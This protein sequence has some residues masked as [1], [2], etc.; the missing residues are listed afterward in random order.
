VYVTVSFTL[1]KFCDDTIY[2]FDIDCDVQLI[3][4]CSNQE[5]LKIQH[6]N[7]W[8]ECTV[9]PTTV[10]YEHLDTKNVSTFA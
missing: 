7:I 10:C 5:M 8:S 9:D 1:Y 6:K 2:P 4:K 3:V